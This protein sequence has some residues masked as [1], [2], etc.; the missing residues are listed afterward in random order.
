MCDSDLQFS[1]RVLRDVLCSADAPLKSETRPI[2]GAASN[3]L[4]RVPVLAGLG[5]HV[6]HDP[7]V[8]G[9]NRLDD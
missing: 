7:V 8:P 9:E 5:Y 3:R 6:V 1:E 2:L 4:Y